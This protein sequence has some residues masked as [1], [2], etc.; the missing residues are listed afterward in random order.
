[1][2][3]TIAP[4]LLGKNGMYSV[5]A[6][7]SSTGLPKP[8]T[9]IPGQTNPDKDEHGTWAVTAGDVE[10][11]DLYFEI[12]DAAHPR[13]VAEFVVEAMQSHATRLRRSRRSCPCPGSCSTGATSL[14]LVSAGTLPPPPSPIARDGRA[15]APTVSRHEVACLGGLFHIAAVQ[16]EICLLDGRSDLVE[17]VEKQSRIAQRVDEGGAPSGPKPPARGAVSN[18]RSMRPSGLLLRTYST[19]RLATALISVSLPPPRLR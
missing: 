15:D 19:T 4:N 17:L 12:A 14:L 10:Q 2:A 9:V 7:G 6:A 3:E 13:Q 11:Y 8:W 18:A 5:R 16:D 1:M